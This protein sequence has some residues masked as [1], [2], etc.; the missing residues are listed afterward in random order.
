MTPALEFRAGVEMFSIYNHEKELQS[1]E[2][3]ISDASYSERGKKLL[4]DF[5]NDLYTGM[6]RVQIIFA[7]SYLS[8]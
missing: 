4:F 3:R 8:S 1:V 5:E 7:V 2:K 6:R